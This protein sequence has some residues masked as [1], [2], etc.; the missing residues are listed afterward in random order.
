MNTQ[1]KKIEKNQS[2]SLFLPS[3]LSAISLY[4]VSTRHPSSLAIFPGVCRS[5][6]TSWHVRPERYS[7]PNRLFLVIISIMEKWDQDVSEE[8][9]AVYNTVQT[10]LCIANVT[11]N[12]K[13]KIPRPDL[14][15]YSVRSFARVVRRVKL[16]IFCTDGPAARPSGFVY[17]SPRQYALTG[18]GDDLG[19]EGRMCKWAIIAWRRS[20]S[21][22]SC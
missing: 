18:L 17:G 15:F 13:K 19:S 12:D 21:L 7:A 3:L 6:D 14:F 4:L 22:E 1:N 20:R 9:S 16:F 10:L 8:D 5:N 11:P 2:I